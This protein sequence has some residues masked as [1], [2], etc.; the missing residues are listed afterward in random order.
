MFVQRRGRPAARWPWLH[1]TLGLSWD[2]C[3][4][5]ENEL[6]HGL[7]AWQ[8]SDCHTAISTS[9]SVSLNAIQNMGATIQGLTIGH[10]LKLSLT[11]IHCLSAADKQDIFIW[12]Q[13]GCLW[14]LL[15]WPYH[16]TTHCTSRFIHALKEHYPKLKLR[17]IYKHIAKFENTFKYKEVQRSSLAP[18][19]ASFPS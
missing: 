9:T 14:K 11:A 15:A 6:W 5:Q 1:T 13:Y 19:D 17:R 12:A 7:L 18:F 3:Q 10:R 4:T 8:T 2:V 16:D